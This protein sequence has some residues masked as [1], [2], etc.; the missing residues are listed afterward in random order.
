MPLVTLKQILEEA[1][2][3]GYGVGAYNVNNMEQVQGIMKAARATKSPVII[4]CSRGALAYS[5]MVYLKKL[6]EAAIE[7]NPDIPICVHLDHGD[8]FESCVNAIGLGFSS[9]MIDC[10][11]KPFEDNVRITKQV[12]DYA[13]ERGVSVEAEIGTLGGIE[14]DIS[15]K[16]QLTDPEEAA[17]FVELTGVDA[18]AV[19][20]G[21]SHGAYKFPAGSNPKIDVE[22]VAEIKKLVTVPLVMHGSSSVPAELRDEV[23]KY[24]GK[25]PDAIG[26]PMESICDAIGKGVRKIN[27]DSDSRMAMTGAVRKVFAEHPDKFDP[28]EY[29]GP[30]R[31]AIAVLLEDKMRR[32]GTAGHVGEYTCKTLEEMKQLYAESKK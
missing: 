29:L 13:H 30:A 12:V 27:V 19:A 9:V 25:M 15:G 28:R 3:K 11:H 26:I 2:K 18:L 21:T 17:R 8:T 16:V 32:F 22:R 24:G 5:N 20:I 7:E 1:D 6:M 10:S 4:Q 31:D 14:E 23:N